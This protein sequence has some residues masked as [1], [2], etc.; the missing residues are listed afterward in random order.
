MGMN[1]G[2]ASSEKVPQAWIVLSSAGRSLDVEATIKKLDIWHKTVVS[3]YKWLQGG[4]EVID[5]VDFVL[6]ELVMCVMFVDHTDSEIMDGESFEESIAGL[7]WMEN[8][9]ET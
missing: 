9:Q 1:I 5:E 2:H 8:V 7:I 3:K 4:I 6:K